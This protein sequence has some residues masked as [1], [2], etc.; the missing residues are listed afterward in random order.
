M[1]L[2]A[3]HSWDA[4]INSAKNGA[5]SKPACDTAALTQSAC[6]CLHM[7]SHVVPKRIRTGHGDMW[8]VCSGR[9]AHSAPHAR[10]H[11]YHTWQRYG[12]PQD[13]VFL[14]VSPIHT[15]VRYFQLPQLEPLQCNAECAASALLGC[16]LQLMGQNNTA[17]CSA[18]GLKS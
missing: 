14:L 7:L 13:S 8:K 6:G 17:A 12:H 11:R 16:T 18:S 9:D 4:I 15:T 2:T 1:H 3:C 5:T 10:V